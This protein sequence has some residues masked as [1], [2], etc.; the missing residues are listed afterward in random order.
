MI[1]LVIND[2][3]R[4][5]KASV[6]FPW[7]WGGVGLHSHF[8][9]QPNYSVEVVLCSVVGVGAVTIANMSCLIFWAPDIFFVLSE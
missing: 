7:W 1:T 4:L 3:L 5:L 9:V 8:H 2:N 6:E